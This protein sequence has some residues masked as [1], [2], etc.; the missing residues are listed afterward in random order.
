M[1]IEQTIQQAA[2]KQLAILLSND[3]TWSRVKAAVNLQD[4][5]N[6]PGNEKKE[7]CLKL[8]KE[9]GVDL[10]TWLINLLIE[11][12]VAYLKQNVK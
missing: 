2:I 3:T 12:A 7:A 10:A 11:L 9:M 6:T 4:D 5:P 8:L 1:K